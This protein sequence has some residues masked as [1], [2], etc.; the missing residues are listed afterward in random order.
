MAGL[1]DGGNEPAV[2]TCYGTKIVLQWLKEGKLVINKISQLGPV[3]PS[4]N[5]ILQTFWGTMQREE[6]EYKNNWNTRKIMR[7][8]GE[9]GE[10]KQN[11]QGEYK[12]DEPTLRSV[13]IEEKLDR[14]RVEFPGSS[15][16]RALTWTFT[17]KEENSLRSFERK[18]LRRIFGPVSDHQ[19]WRIRS[20]NE[21]LN[22]IGGQ[23]VVKFMKAQTLRWLGHH[24][25]VS[26]QFTARLSWL[27]LLAQSLAFTESRTPDLQRRSAALRTQVPQLRSTALELRASG[28]TV[29][30]T[31]QVALWSR[32]WLAV[33]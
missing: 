2:L 5:S 25:T 6:G 20:N 9:Q 12:E 27:V 30:D 8:K 17:K 13:D 14:Y 11:E 26:S 16:G 3:D 32:S 31:T 1:C 33:H 7:M 4:T 28:S 21:L 23:D 24:R 29:T 10:Y 19:G 18:I 15:V 22:L